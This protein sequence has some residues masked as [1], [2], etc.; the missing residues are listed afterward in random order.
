MAKFE[1]IVFNSD[2]LKS[3]FENDKTHYKV[4]VLI[5]ASNVGDHFDVFTQCWNKY[6]NSN[7]N[8]K[9]FFL[10]SIPHINSDIFVTENTIIHNYQESFEPGI[11]YKTVAGMKICEKYFTYDYMLRTNLS[12]FYHFERLLDFLD[13]Q[14]LL[15]YAAAKQNIYRDD[16]GFLSGAGFILSRDIVIKFLSEIFDKHALCED[17]VRHPDDVVITMIIK[18][19]IT[20]NFYHLD[21]FDCEDVVEPEKIDKHIFHIRNKT[22]WK[23]GNRDIDMENI[24]KLYDSFYLNSS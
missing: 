21:R 20:G 8:I 18:R 22:E 15:E 11:L 19:F 5:I 1:N 17:I 3:S 13:K 24:K 12:S 14:P 6:M 10:Y 2:S 16:I 23:Y 7:P 9:S 4:L